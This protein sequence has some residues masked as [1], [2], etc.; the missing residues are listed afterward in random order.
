[1]GV[2]L[3]TQEKNANIRFLANSYNDQDAMYQLSSGQ[4]AIISFAFTLSLNTTFKI[5]DDL[6][7]LI[8]DDPIQD[9]DAMN[10][11]AL[12][13]MLRHS[14][15]NYQIIM[16]THSD[17]SAMF[18]K[19]KFDRMDSDSESKVDLINVKTLFLEGK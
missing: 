17:S 10:V 4:I 1:M 18:I 13:D 16:S 9:M 7:I 8:I 15:L 11:Y 5:S 14:L 19:Y 2:F 12:I 3:T 6:K